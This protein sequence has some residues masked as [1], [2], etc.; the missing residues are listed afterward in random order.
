ML[1]WLF[2]TQSYAQSLAQ[3]WFPRAIS[4]TQTE[5]EN[6]GWWN[7]KAC[8]WSTRF[9]LII[10]EIVYLTRMLQSI[11]NSY[12]VVYIFAYI[13]VAANRYIRSQP[14]P[15][16]SSV[17]EQKKGKNLRQIERERRE[18]CGREIR[19]LNRSLDV[20]KMEP[21]LMECRFHHNQ[22]PSLAPFPIFTTSYAPSSRNMCVSPC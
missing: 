7:S 11:S 6:F 15:H 8:F 14:I 12:P 16:Q 10:L 5:R 18:R 13:F 4:F 21:G 19:S 17:G 2:Q 20:G 3:H 9:D 1:L 22:L